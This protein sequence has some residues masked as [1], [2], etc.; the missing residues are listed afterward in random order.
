MKLFAIYVFAAL[1]GIT[2]LQACGS[3]DVTEE[4]N[5]QAIEDS[6]ALAQAEEAQREQMRRDSLEQA[7]ADSIAAEEE[8]RRV[9]YS[10]DGDYVVQVESW[11]SQEKAERQTGE[12]KQK[13]Y[14]R[15]AVVMYGSEGT[16]DI[17]YRVRLGQFESREMAERLKTKLT[18]EYGAQAWVSRKG[19]APTSQLLHDN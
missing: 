5:Q 10:D 19:A 1:L 11:R 4:Q 18:E 15:A 8:R 12:W 16:G 17:W 7:R 6:L 2:L 9:E 13:G 14:D 3:D